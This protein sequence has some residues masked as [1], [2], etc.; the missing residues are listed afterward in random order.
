MFA[1]EFR[2]KQDRNL[3]TKAEY[4]RVLRI[5]KDLVMHGKLSGE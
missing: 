4:M 3:E 2:M 5:S 1:A